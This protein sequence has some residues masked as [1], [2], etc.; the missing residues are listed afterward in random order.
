MTEMDLPSL[1][2]HW[3]CTMSVTCRRGWRDEISRFSAYVTL[4]RWPWPEEWEDSED[5]PTCIPKW[6]FRSRLSQFS[7]LI[8]ASGKHGVYLKAD[9]HRFAST[10]FNA[11]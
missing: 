7:P 11:M 2:L 8:T 1:Q 5:R 10:I 4:T 9:V 6:T 3:D